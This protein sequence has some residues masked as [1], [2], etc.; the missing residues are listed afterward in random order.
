ME[1]WKSEGDGS[2]FNNNGIQI[3]NAA[4]VAV[5]HVTCCR[6]RSGGLVTTEVRRLRVNDFDSYDNQFDGLACYQT[7]QSYFGALRLHDNL[8]AGISLDL[9]F[10]HNCVT[11]AILAGNDLGIFMRDSRDNSFRGL[12]I[13]KSRHHGV[14][15]AQSDIPTVK[16]WR[17]CPD[18][19]C[20][21]NRFQSLTVN[22]CGGKAF[23]VNDASC[24]NNAIDGARFL[25]TSW[26][27]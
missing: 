15:M 18:T 12:T 20:I 6:C 24:T 3:W 10:S 17:L 14:F 4:D 5:E 22:N 2:E 25:E 23:L 7:E 1:L 8:A 21:G 9:D 11:N 13:S 19:E 26:V 16:G 27:A